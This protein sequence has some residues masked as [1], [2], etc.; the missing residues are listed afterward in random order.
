MRNN[1]T[2][3]VTRRAIGGW[4]LEGLNPQGPQKLSTA[5]ISSVEVSTS[6]LW[7]PFD[8]VCLLALEHLFNIKIVCALV[9]LHWLCLDGFG[10]LGLVWLRTLVASTLVEC[11]WGVSV[12][13]GCTL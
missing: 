7:S 6:L 8:T 11:M 13:V 9:R 12:W 3:F 2:S 10:L 4:S 1:F 5:L